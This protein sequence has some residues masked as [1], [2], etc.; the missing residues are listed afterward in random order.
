METRRFQIGKSAW[1]EWCR[2]QTSSFRNL[3]Q[4][5]HIHLELLYFGSLAVFSG[6]G[7]HESQRCTSESFRLKTQCIY[8]LLMGKSD[9]PDMTIWNTA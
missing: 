8:P 3:T 7:L 6:N 9:D 2:K 5:M 4:T 1:L